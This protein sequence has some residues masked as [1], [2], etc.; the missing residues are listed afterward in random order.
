MTWNMAPTQHNATKDFIMGKKEQRKD[1]NPN[2]ACNLLAKE[3]TER[4]NNT[5]HATNER[6]W[7]SNTETE[8]CSILMMSEL[9]A[10]FKQELRT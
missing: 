2:R 3:E 5:E 8:E 9:P 4:R 10:S 1:I 6:A 7:K